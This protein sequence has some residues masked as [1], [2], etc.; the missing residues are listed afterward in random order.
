[1]QSKYGYSFWKSLYF[2]RILL[3]W[4]GLGFVTVKQRKTN[5]LIKTYTSH[6]FYVNFMVNS[7][8]QYIYIIFATNI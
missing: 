1:M 3:V 5:C 2:Y 7:E 8:V 6:V 4:T